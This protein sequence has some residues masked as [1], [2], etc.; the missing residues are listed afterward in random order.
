MYE[1]STEM[2]KISGVAS[3]LAVVAVSILFLPQLGD[4]AFAKSKGGNLSSPGM[5]W[6]LDLTKVQ[7][8]NIINEE[9]NVEK[10]IL[11]LKQSIRDQKKELDSLLS[12]D[13][14]D[15]SK[16]N[17]LIDNISKNIAEIQKK[18]VFF[19]IWI[20]QQLTPEQKEKLLGLMKSMQTQGP[21]GEARGF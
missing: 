11:P 18:Q 5:V 8:D 1:R 12:A 3:V 16:I 15:S 9:N 13:N 7:K 21:S 10:E 4:K 14:P 2:K 6:R 20:R 17:R 19:M